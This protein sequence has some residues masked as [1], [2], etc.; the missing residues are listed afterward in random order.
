[1]ISLSI[2]SNDERKWELKLFQF[3][4]TIW[5]NFEMYIFSMANKN[6]F[7]NENIE[8]Y[9]NIVD[10]WVIKMEYDLIS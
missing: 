5:E 7:N 4:K 8:I 1:M 9:S 2:V 6:I 3:F 10:Y